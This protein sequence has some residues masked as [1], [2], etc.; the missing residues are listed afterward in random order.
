M[1]PLLLQ[2][3]DLEFL[4]PPEL[5]TIPESHLDIPLRKNNPSSGSATVCPE[6]SSCDYAVA[7]EELT[8]PATLVPSAA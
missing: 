3:Q 5:V 6:D 8:P 2:G 4:K 1:P 7:L